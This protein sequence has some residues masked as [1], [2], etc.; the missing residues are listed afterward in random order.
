MTWQRI[1]DVEPT[2]L[3]DVRLQLHWAAQAAAGV[4][5][6][7]LT[8]Q[9]D[10]S[11]ESFE[12]SPSHQGLV[13]G[14]V[15]G[16]P[17][18]RSGIRFRDLTLL[19]IDGGDGSAVIDEFPMSGRSLTEGY[20][21]YQKRC[22]SLL[23]RDV[24]IDR[25]TEEMPAHPVGSGARFLVSDPALLG[26][27]GRYYTDAD[28]LLAELSSTEKG[29]G[30]VR[31]WPHHFDIATLI[32]VSGSDEEARTI[33]VGMSPGDSTIGEPYWYVTPWPSGMPDS[34]PLLSHGRWNREGWFGALLRASEIAGHGSEAQRATISRFLA[35][36]TLHCRSLLVES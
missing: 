13:E 31:C 2:S 26:E 29:A 34:L 9:P 20:D 32:T 1:G 36:A 15:E 8:K 22:S 19:L 33:G 6:S 4:G 18:F 3:T 24:T 30:E 35:E 28:Q 23:G 14:I 27:V 17:A 16:P 25:S 7:L 5:R 10:F 12:W 11:H 21:F